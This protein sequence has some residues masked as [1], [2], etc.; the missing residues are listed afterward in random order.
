MTTSL[1]LLSA[2]EADC[3]S[4]LR[5]QLE[6]AQT[7]EEAGRAVTAAIAPLMNPQGNAI[8]DLP[9]EEG[10]AVRTLLGV[11]M[12][13][14]D[15]LRRSYA[16]TIPM[17][18]AARS[19]KHE[20]MGVAGSTAAAVSVS[21]MLPGPLGIGAGLLAG[22]FAGMTTNRFTRDHNTTDLSMAVF[23]IQPE[24]IIKAVRAVLIQAQQFAEQ[25]ILARATVAEKEVSDFDGLLDLMQMLL[26]QPEDD[27]STLSP[28]LQRQV[29]RFLI[30]HGITVERY[31]SDEG[32]APDPHVWVVESVMEAGLPRTLVPALRHHDH[33]LRRGKL[34]IQCASSTLVEKSDLQ[35]SPSSTQRDMK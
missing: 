30:C 23:Q 17:P 24:E 22:L 35:T 20:F 28:R 7:P 3:E 27:E 13:S 25:S 6:S 8:G 1:N 10:Q 5:R 33:V 16:T 19:T 11:I 26:S 4:A 18:P 21:Q 29:A 14:C 2:F 9:R 34:L 12:E 32:R 15:V 31:Q